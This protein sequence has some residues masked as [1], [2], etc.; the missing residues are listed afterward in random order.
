MAG[1]DT[2]TIEILS[3]GTIKTTTDPISKQ[4]HQSCELFL[5]GVATL[6]GG[7]TKRERRTDAAALQRAHQGHHHSHTHEIAK[8]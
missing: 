6:A 7:E 3:D 1:F 8:H 2:L 5:Q 4:N